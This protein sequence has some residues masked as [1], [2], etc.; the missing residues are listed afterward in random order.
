MSLLELESEIQKD[1]DIM[2]ELIYITINNLLV[3]VKSIYGFSTVRLQ[4]DNGFRAVIEQQ[5]FNFYVSTADVKTYGIVADLTFYVQDH[6][7]KY[8]FTI[9]QKPVP[10]L[11]GW[12]RLSCN[13][14]NISSL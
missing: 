5:M 14:I 7:N 9:M 1:L 11:D 13:I 3:P 8:T 4:D 2:G 6:T 10:S 12:S